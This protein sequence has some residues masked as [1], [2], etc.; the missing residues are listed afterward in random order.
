MCSHP[1]R[2]ARLKPGDGLDN[3]SLGLVEF[4]YE[5]L[6]NRFRLTRNEKVVSSIEP[7]LV[8]I[9]TP[10]VLIEISLEEVY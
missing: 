7:P 2:L 3:Q 5:G 6:W 10:L 8:L 9:V 1:A 4:I